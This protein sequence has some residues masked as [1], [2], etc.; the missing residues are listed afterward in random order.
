MYLYLIPMLLKFV[1]V[2]VFILSLAIGLFFVYIYAPD[3]RTIYV[4]PTPDN[5]DMVQYKDVLGN[6]FYYHQERVKCPKESEI[7]TIPPQS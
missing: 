2:P 6:C 4:Y 7:Q 1:N 3:S 5:V